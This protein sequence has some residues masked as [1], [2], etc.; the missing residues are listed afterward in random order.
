MGGREVCNV[1]EIVYMNWVFCGRQV[2]EMEWM[3][4]HT[5]EERLGTVGVICLLFT[6][7]ILCACA[8]SQFFFGKLAIKNN[9]T[10]SVG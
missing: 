2:V 9:Y 4:A 8:V 1:C 6:D 3:V 5:H 7:T 10:T